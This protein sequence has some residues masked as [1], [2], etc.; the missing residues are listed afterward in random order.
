MPSISIGAS[1]IRLSRSLAAVVAV[2]L[3][4]RWPQVGRPA[5]ADPR[6]ATQRRHRDHPASVH[7]PAQDAADGGNQHGDAFTAQRGGELTLAPHP[8]VGAQFLHGLGQRR[9]PRELAPF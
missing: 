3:S 4:A 1:R 6:V 2:A 9:R 5:A 8:I 7:Q